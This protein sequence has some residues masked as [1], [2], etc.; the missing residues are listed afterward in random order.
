MTIRNLEF[1]SRP[2][3]VAVIGASD[4][5]GS[6]G[7]VV[8]K[9]ILDGGF[10][11][12]VYPVNPKYR[13]VMGLACYA[14]AADLPEAPDLAVIVTP[15]QT[16][17][18]VV[19]ELGARGV[20]AA[21]VIT[22]GINKTNGLRQKMLDAARPHLL[23]I[24][25]PNTVG[26]MIP[27][28]KLNAGFAHMAAAPGDIA[29]LS[30]SGAIATSLIDWAAGRGIGFS[31]IVSLGDMAD[32]DVADYIDMLAGDGRTRAIMLYLESVPHPRKFMS[33]ARA[34]ARIK[35]VIAIKPGRHEQAA[36]A[37]ATHTGALSGADRVVDAAL[38]RVGILRVGGLAELF[39]A[40][41]IVARFPP[42]KRVR[43]G[44]VTNG[45][46]AGV[47]AVDQLMDIGGELAELAPET[48]ETLNAGLPPTWSHANPVDII[49][50]APAERY[51][52]A[53]KAVAADRNVDAVLV[54][55]CPTGLA[56]PLEAAQGVAA[57]VDK[58]RIDGKP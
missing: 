24:L 29:L 21:V 10:E 6:V 56:S 16:V 23:R 38:R 39:D 17:P 3:S 57:V 1:M 45:G 9:N 44:I 41:E 52:A 42:L 36:K 19:G 4:R 33:A 40:V 35:P 22:A 20:K 32:V 28:L 51:G 2:R 53:L 31:H 34:A 43:V 55:N 37:A 30:Q 48:I 12:P 25:G 54:L 46:G 11:G 26:L 13:K 5:E 50:D 47:L 15:P 18:G 49:G 7:G 27:P 58:G 8:L 14:S